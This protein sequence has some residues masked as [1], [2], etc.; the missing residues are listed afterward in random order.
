MTQ[1][2]PKLRQGWTTG[3][4][5]TAATKAALQVLWGGQ[6]V[7]R[8][9]ITLPR[10]QTPVFA[11]EDITQG[12]GWVRA[13]VRKDAGD[14]PDVTHGAI[15]TATVRPTQGGG[16]VFRA[17]DG[18]GH[19]TRA[20]LPLPVG[21][22]AINPVPRQMMRAVVQQAAAL[23]GRPVDIE[24]T[25]SIP[26]GAALAAKTWNPRLGIEGGVVDFRHNGDCQAVFLCGLDCLHPSRH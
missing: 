12:H 3:A 13:A 9:Q 19:V 14:D 15:V 16:V 5:A 23:Y 10:G 8:V 4:C 11:I 18:V 26:G 24:I 25:L 20:G 17:G 2:T 22:P 21:E 6:V 1:N 7:D